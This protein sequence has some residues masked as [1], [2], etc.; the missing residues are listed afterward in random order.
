MIGHSSHS[1][2]TFLPNFFFDQDK[3]ILYI[4]I[5]G[6]NDTDGQNVEIFNQLVTKWIFNKVGPTKLIFPGTKE[7]FLS[8]RCE[9]FRDLL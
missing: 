1:S 9:G 8:S 3:K 4:D 6:L 5:A 2:M 7:G